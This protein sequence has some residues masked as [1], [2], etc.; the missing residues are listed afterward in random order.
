MA[1]ET[2]HPRKIT[3]T[4]GGWLRRLIVSPA[5]RLRV[6]PD[7]NISCDREVF[8][9]NERIKEALIK[10]VC[11]ELTKG[12]YTCTSSKGWWWHAYCKECNRLG[13]TVNTLVVI[14]AED[15]DWFSSVVIAQV[16]VP[17]LNQILIVMTCLPQKLMA[18][19]SSCL[20]TLNGR[21]GNNT[22]SCTY[23]KCS[24]QK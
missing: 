4:C 21:S 19:K 7:L 2:D 5:L 13:E 16:T 24:L 12:N 20:R 6:N 8:L 15:T 11:A 17:F 9:A 3:S 23:Q 1:T 10:L 14:A 18:M 22:V